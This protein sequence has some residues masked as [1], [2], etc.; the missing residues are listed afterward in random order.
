LR[1]VAKAAGGTFHFL[2][3]GFLVAARLPGF[4]RLRGAFLAVYVEEIIG[5]ASG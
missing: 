1:W 4:G 5:A 3:T 2:F